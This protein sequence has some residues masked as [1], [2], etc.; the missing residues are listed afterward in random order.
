MHENKY[1]LEY[2]I[3]SFMELLRV[4]IHHY[5][6]KVGSHGLY[7]VFGAVFDTTAVSYVVSLYFCRMFR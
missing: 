3:G 1:L 4:L 6:G 7:T 2:D 5:L